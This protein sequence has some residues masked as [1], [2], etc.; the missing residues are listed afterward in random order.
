MLSAHLED[1]Q[2]HGATFAGANL[3]W[4]WIT[5]VDFREADLSSFQSPDIQMIRDFVSKHWGT[6]GNC[7]AALV[8]S[9]DLGFGLSRMYEFFI[10][11]KTTN[12]VKV[13]R[14]IEEAMEWITS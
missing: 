2:V 4:A 10:E 11:D 8:V 14:Q 7:K 1:A 3:E 13:F 5:G 6:G 9:G 12:D